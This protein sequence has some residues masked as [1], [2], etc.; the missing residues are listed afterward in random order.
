MKHRPSGVH[1]RPDGRTEKNPASAGF[2]ECANAKIVPAAYATF[3]S[4]N[5]SISPAKSEIGTQL[6]NT[7]LSP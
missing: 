3:G 4:L 5:A 6:Q 2:F 1:S 7:F